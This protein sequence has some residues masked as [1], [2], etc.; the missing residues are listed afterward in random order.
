MKQVQYL[1]SAANGTIQYQAKATLA[2]GSVGFS[3]VVT[4]TVNIPADESVLI[5]STGMADMIEIPRRDTSRA[6][7]FR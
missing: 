7:M 3:N 6:V 4:V 5:I 2:D 1:S